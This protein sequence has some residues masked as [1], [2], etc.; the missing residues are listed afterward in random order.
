MHC[1]IV[2]T[3]ME[4]LNNTMIAFLEAGLQ[5]TGTGSARVAQTCLRRSLVDVF[6]MDAGPMAPNDGS[7][8]A[9]LLD[10]AEARN[11][12][13]VT[14]LLTQDVAEDTEA[15]TKAYQS[16]HCVLGHDVAPRLAAKLALASLAERTVVSG[17]DVE[18][19]LPRVMPSRTPVFQSARAA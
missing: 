13:L 6:V 3:Q 12:Q 19:V 8:R 11:E 1:L 5:V 2:D 14:L 17:F 15:M 4:R 10:L 16:V 18:P 9:R 7:P